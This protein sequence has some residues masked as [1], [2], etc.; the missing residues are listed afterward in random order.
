MSIK[1]LKQDVLERTRN[2]T[3]TC[4]MPVPV[5]AGR[6]MPRTGLG[7]TTALFAAGERIRVLENALRG[8]GEDIH[9]ESMCQK[10][11]NFSEELKNCWSRIDWLE[12]KLQERGLSLPGAG[13]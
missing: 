10:S 4:E 6:Q 2:V 5:Q 3:P 11:H 12:A 7:I 8:N 1:K 9:R 13:T